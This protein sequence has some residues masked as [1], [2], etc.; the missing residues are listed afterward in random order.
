MATETEGKKTSGEEESTDE[1]SEGAEQAQEE[2][3]DES[4]VKTKSELSDGVAV[5]A[6]SQLGATR[7]VMASF[8]LATIAVAFVIGKLLSLIW[9]RL[10]ESASLQQSLG[11][12]ARVSEDERAEITTVVG[13]VV[14]LLGAINAYRRPDVR[15]WAD[16]VASELAKV[17]WPDK[18]E[19]ADSTLVVVVT[20]A[21]ATVYLALLDRFWGFVTNLVYGSGLGLGALLCRKSGT[22]FRPTR[23]TKTK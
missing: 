8:F 21:F 12:L 17:T 4:V 2:G 20:S 11:F 5:S 7:Y 1:A 22:S 19:V 6:A 23:A 18:G 15:R 3:A 16:E 10:A 13:G 9:G 14:G